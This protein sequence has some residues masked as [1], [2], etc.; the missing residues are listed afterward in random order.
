MNIS[1]FHL[2]HNI[3]VQSLKARG[4]VEV[5]HAVGYNIQACQALIKPM[6][7]DGDCRMYLGI[8]SQISKE[9]A[10]GTVSSRVSTEAK[11]IR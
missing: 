5:N 3:F 8:V 6:I 1:V 4:H 2:R 7:K 11:G 9:P 10:T